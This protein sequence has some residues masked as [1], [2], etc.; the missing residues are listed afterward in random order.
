MSKLLD[1]YKDLKRSD[2]NT[3]YLFKSGVF[4]IFLDSDALIMS[5][6]LNLK[7]TP[8]NSQTLKCG[9][10]ESALDKYLRLINNS[11]YHIQ[12]IDSSKVS[13]S[14]KQYNETIQSKKLINL[15]NNIDVEN[16]SIKEAFDFINNLKKFV[17]DVE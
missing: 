4:Y 13:H 8:L 2:S 5:N 1:F 11:A 3:L 12:I 6:L 10:P 14:I 15:I 17:K 16:L 7:L 9:F